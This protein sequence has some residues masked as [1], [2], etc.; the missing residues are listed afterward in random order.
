MTSSVEELARTSAGMA[1][2]YC[3]D[4]HQ[5]IEEYDGGGTLQ[6]WYFYGPGIDEPMFMADAGWLGG[7]AQCDRVG[8][9]RDRKMDCIQEI[10][11]GG[12]CTI[13]KHRLYH[14]WIDNHD[15]VKKEVWND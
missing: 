5:I 3:Y 6:R 11:A 4:G 15:P 12:W 14:D 1:T 9:N 10:I 8:F 2:Q 7:I 13:P